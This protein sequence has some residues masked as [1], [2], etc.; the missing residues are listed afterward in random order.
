MRIL[1]FSDL[2]GH[3]FRQC[4]TTLKNG[5]NSRLQDA[6]DVLDEI[7]DVCLNQEIDGVLFGGDLFHT[8]GTLKVSTFNAIFEGI[9]KIKTAVNFFGML[10]GNHDQDTKIGDTHACYAFSSILTVMD[11]PGWYAFEA[12]DGEP[13]QVYAIPYTTDKNQV[14]ADLKTFG[15]AQPPGYTSLCLAHLGVSGAEVGSNFVLISEDNITIKA[16]MDAKFDHVFLGHYHRPQVLAPRVHYIGA[17]HQ[18]NWGDVGQERGFLIYDTSDKY[19]YLESNAPKFVKVEGLSGGAYSCDGS[20][21]YPR[22]NFVRVVYSSPPS[23]KE[24]GD[25]KKA[26]FKDGARWVEQWVAPS[27]VAP[28]CG[29]SVS[30]RPGRDF[31]DMIVSFVRKSETE[32]LDEEKLIKIGKS[33]LESAQ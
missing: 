1:L 15:S 25:V 19:K 9:A 2:H 26:L 29:D 31:E 30:F 4:S 17:T 6:I 24:W 5:R 18:H 14:E 11:H 28:L 7:Y 33:I 20:T 27:T 12:A 21:G 23:P 10:V 16:L 3:A 32:G 8:K 13:L 22:N